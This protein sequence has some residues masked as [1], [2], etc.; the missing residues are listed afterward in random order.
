M[1]V[2]LYILENRDKTMEKWNNWTDKP[3]ANKANISETQLK[4]IDAKI[5]KSLD[6][7]HDLEKQEANWDD[8]TSLDDF[9]NSAFDEEKNIQLSELV[10]KN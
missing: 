7:T 1:I 3:V 6:L 8:D 5:R 2:L 4:E 9:L 10:K